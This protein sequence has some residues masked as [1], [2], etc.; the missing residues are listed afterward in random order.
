MNKIE[1]IQYR[2]LQV[3]Q[4]D[5]DFNYNIL[6]KKPGKCSVV[7]RRPRTMAL[8]I[9]KSLNDFSFMKNIFNK[10]NNVAKEKMTL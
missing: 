7:L 8:E 5:Y 4:N 1:R 9:F 2:A 3:I 6:L 10:R